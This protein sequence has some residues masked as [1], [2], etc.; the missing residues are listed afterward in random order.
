MSSSGNQEAAQQLLQIRILLGIVGFGVGLGF[1]TACGQIA[2]PVVLPVV[3]FLAG[4]EMATGW[5]LRRR[6]ANPRRGMALLLGYIGWG[7]MRWTAYGLVGFAMLIGVI[8]VFVHKVDVRAISVSEAAITLFL[9]ILLSFPLGFALG[10]VLQFIAFL[11]GWALRVSPYVDQSVINA[12]LENR[13]PPP[14]R[15]FPPQPAQAPSDHDGYRRN[16]PAVVGML[17]TL[18][19]LYTLLPLAGDT[20]FHS[21]G[22][23]VGVFVGIAGAVGGGFLAARGTQAVFGHSLRSVSPRDCWPELY[24]DPA[25]HEATKHPSNGR[26]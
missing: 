26:S 21:A 17:A 8:F 10:G 4:P 5:W 13:Y 1:F 16:I 25:D 9:G 19:L 6:D 2:V 15:D 14:G 20:A 11:V 12:W 3:V 23:V 7:V 18:A 22:G 24:P